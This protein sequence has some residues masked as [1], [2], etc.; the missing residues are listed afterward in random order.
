[1]VAATELAGGSCIN[2]SITVSTQQAAILKLATK[3]TIDPIQH[4][5]SEVSVSAIIVETSKHRRTG[6]FQCFYGWACRQ[7]SLR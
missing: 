4:I 5:I 2:C 3:T 1:M 6:T 7:F